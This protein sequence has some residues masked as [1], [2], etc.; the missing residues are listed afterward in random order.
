MTFHHYMNDDITLA[1]LSE[2]ITRKNKDG[3]RVYVLSEDFHGEE[4]VMPSVTS[5]TS[6]FSEEGIKNWRKRVGEE[7]ANK[8]MVKA[9]RRGT[10]VHNIAE[11][12]ISNKDNWSEGRMPSH[13][14]TFEKL[15]PVIDKNLQTVYLQE[16]KLYSHE[17]LVAGK[18]DLICKWSD[19]NCCVDWKTSQKPKK[20]NYIHNYFM[21]GAAYCKAFEERTGLTME[22]IVICIAVDNQQEPQI[23]VEDWRDWIE[24]F[25]Q[26]RLQYKQRYGI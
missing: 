26:L 21:Q 2:K 18:P 25:K 22:K 4:L 23:F 13:M 14:E 11:D 9:S 17:L 19:K 3:K 12:Y 16:K 15:R 1:N 20:H 8:I 6:L 7:Q 5:V 10:A 24:P